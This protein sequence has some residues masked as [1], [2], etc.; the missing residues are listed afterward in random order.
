MP[1]DNP[2]HGSTSHGCARQHRALR[3]RDLAN[4]ALARSSVFGV[5]EFKPHHR[6][7]GAYTWPPTIRSAEP[8][9]ALTSTKCCPQPEVERGTSKVL[10][11]GTGSRPHL[12]G[13]VHPEPEA[14]AAM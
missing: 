13:A 5:V 11:N 8:S 2:W 12:Q 14:D 10:Q 7:H 6:G 4:C 9:K 1:T 3:L